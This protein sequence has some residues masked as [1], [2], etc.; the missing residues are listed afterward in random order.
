MQESIR[1]MVHL[2]VTLVERI[3]SLQNTKDVI[4]LSGEKNPIR[5]WMVAARIDIETFRCVIFRIN[6]NGDHLIVLTDVGNIIL[7]LGKSCAQ[8][9][10]NRRATGEDELQQDGS[11]LGQNIREL[12]FLAVPVG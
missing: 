1:P 5:G 11:G 7:C 8:D 6:R 2:V 3:K 12:H 9:R 10:A 4:S